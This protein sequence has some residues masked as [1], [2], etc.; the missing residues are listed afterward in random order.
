LKELIERL[1]AVD[2]TAVRKF[3]SGVAKKGPL[4]L[5]ALGPLEKLESYDR[6]AARFA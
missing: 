3:A 6:V 4:S 5:A 1:E 2:K